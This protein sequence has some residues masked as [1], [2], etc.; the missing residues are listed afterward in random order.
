M[1]PE[2]YLNILY[3]NIILNPLTPGI[4]WGI[5][6]VL[7]LLFSSALVSGSEV[8]YFSLKPEQKQKL[9]DSDTK[10]SN[11]ILKMLAKPEKLLTVNMNKTDKQNILPRSY[12][13]I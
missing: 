13:K 4:I 10:K 7:V 3:L 12:V 2:P 1:D 8:A 11:T 9:K 6:G 5:V